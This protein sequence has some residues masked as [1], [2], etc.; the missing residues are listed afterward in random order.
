MRILVDIGHPA[1]VHLYKNFIREMKQRGHTVLV[2]VKNGLN[3]ATDLLRLY[4]IPYLVVASRADS[5][6]R[7]ATSQLVADYQIAGIVRKNKIELGVG[8]TLSIAHVSSLTS[9]KS[10]VFDDDDDEVEP[11]FVRFGHP[12]CDCLLSPDVLKDRR[13]KRGVVYYPGL[14]ELAYLHPNNFTPDPGVL[15]DAGLLPGERFYLLRFNAF[16]AHHDKHAKGMDTETKRELIQLLQQ[17]GKVLIT[18]EREIESEFSHLKIKVPPDRIHSMIYYASLFIGDS[19]TMTSE[20][21]VLG[22]PSVRLNS[23]AGRIS[24]LEAEEHRY[25]LTFSFLPGRTADMIS[26]TAALIGTPDLRAEWQEKRALLLRE[27]I[28]VTAFMVWFAEF[29]PESRQE[30]LKNPSLVSKFR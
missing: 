16:K 30:M 7:K 3:S 28:D 17:T 25:G 21:A 24:Y 20:A 13:K 8:S 29:F 18:A 27:M 11:L 26:K 12:F 23:F 22:T 10:I 1:H 2:T 5:L 14:H 19:Q 9:M 4:N 15:K 6:L